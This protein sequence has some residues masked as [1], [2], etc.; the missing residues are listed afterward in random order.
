M[1]ENRIARLF[2][3]S[4]TLGWL[5]RKKKQELALKNRKPASA[6]GKSPLLNP[7]G[8]LF[9][10]IINCKNEICF[11]NQ[12]FL[13]GLIY[14][15]EGVNTWNSLFFTALPNSLRERVEKCFRMEKYFVSGIIWLIQT[16]LHIG[17]KIWNWTWSAEFSNLQIKQNI[18]GRRSIFSDG[19]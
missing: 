5:K 1:M 18:H 16:L 7:V 3:R 17:W 10:K 8:R 2:T 4:S 12:T 13:S 11:R 15:L 19:R 9:I 14:F 6:N